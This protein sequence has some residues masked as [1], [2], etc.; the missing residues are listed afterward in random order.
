MNLEQQIIK[1][2]LKDV[3][4]YTLLILGGGPDGSFTLE[5]VFSSD[6][7]IL[8]LAKNG[9]LLENHLAPEAPI[10]PSN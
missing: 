8:T 10:S 9:R 3:C 7:K 5:C 2:S 6:S 4:N 1:H